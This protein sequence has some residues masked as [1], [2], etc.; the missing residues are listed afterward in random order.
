MN[1]DYILIILTFIF[2]F[3]MAWN[4]GAN[5]VSNAMGTSVGS[6]ALT[7]KKAVIIAAILEF[8]GA[9][10]LGSNVSST[11]QQGI[12]D[13]DFFSFNPMIFVIGMIGALLA[14]GLW[15][16]IASYFHLPISTTH[17]IIG[18]VIGF[19]LII[20]GIKAI[21]WEQLLFITLSWIIAP[22]ISGFIAYIFFSF[23]QKKILYSFNPFDSAKKISPYFIFFIILV[24]SFNI[25]FKGP[26]HLNLHFS[27]LAALSL[28]GSLALIASLISFLLFKRFP[29]LSSTRCIVSPEHAYNLEKAVKY[30]QRTKLS[31]T[32]IIYE[33]SSSLLDE[34]RK[35][36]GDVKKEVKY[37]ESSSQYINVEKIF[38][39][40]QIISACLVAF[41]HGSNDV[42]NAIGPVAA[43]M[44]VIRTKMIPQNFN[45]SPLILFLG[46]IS[47]VIGL[48]TWGWRVIETI[49]KK[50]TELTPTR[51]FTAE[52]ATAFTIIS[53][54]KL[55]LP[56][57]TTHALVGSV[58]GIGLARGLNSI[59]LKTIK[60][61]LLS[62]FVTIPVCALI[63][64]ILF[65]IL[66]F[67]IL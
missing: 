25:L 3:Y 39:Y 41:A 40:L 28:S 31:S 1:I 16:N 10:L 30:L 51:G 67:L 47:M 6:K 34:L 19:G 62:W 9:F 43:I 63:S 59:N 12:V 15:I 48:A 2:G 45:I 37:L 26:K 61:I 24:F 53:A 5:D 60:G 8:S 57:S 65:Y 17:A 11:I 52:I 18:S 23:V 13:P 38:A 4:I 32:G 20:G 58:L 33:K 29:D 27:L 35:F 55:G 50:I 64:I 36:S 42:A 49:G 66:K 46:G 44:Q 14:T 22:I 54:S 7:L 21:H 56:I